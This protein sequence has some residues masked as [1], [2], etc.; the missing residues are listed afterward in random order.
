MGRCLELA[1]EGWGATHPN[2]MVGAA[3]VEGGEIVAEGF[4]AQPGKAHAEIAALQALGRAPA[5]DATMF[6]TLEP[7]ST[8]GRT[9][10]CTDAIIAAGI[11]HVVVGAIDPNPEHQGRGLEQLKAAGLKIESRVLADA[12][13]ELNL[14][15]NHWIVERRPL[16][17][18]KVATTLDGRIATRAGESRWI[19]GEPARADVMCWRRYFPAIAVG[20]G[21]VLHD[22]PRL[23]ARVAGQREWCPVRFVFDGMLR[24]AVDAKL[25]QLFTD[26]FKERTI[27]VTSDQ[28]ATGYVRRLKAA[29]VNVWELPAIAGRISFG[30]FRERCAAAEI[31]GVLVEGGA[32]LVSEMLYARAL[33]YLFAY[34]APVLFADDRAKPVARGLRTEQ[35]EQ[36]IRL[37]RVRHANF[38]DDELMR[39]FIAYPGKLH[40]DENAR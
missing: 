5:A 32:Q 15:F 14:I 38:G 18:A 28:A 17:A 4:H 25:P 9:P 33:D 36:A 23:T 30:A 7:C 40:A 3:I 13:A 16:L 20:A 31:S 24:T 21:T 29:G 6:V 10:P 22:N 26:E 37:E 27:V 11:K 12:C 19:T 2:P 39:G 8:H 35:L 34:R 1:R